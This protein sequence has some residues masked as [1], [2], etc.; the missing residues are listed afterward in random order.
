MVT[1]T[2]KLESAANGTAVVGGVE[3]MLCGYGSWVPRV[4]GKALV[5]R[6]QDSNIA[7]A[8][9]GSFSFQVDPND[10]IT[11]EGTYYTVTIK[12]D[13]GDISQINAY[14]F[15]SLPVSYDLTLV[16]PFSPNQPPPPLPPPPVFPPLNFNRL[17]ILP[18]VP[19]MVFDGTT[20]LSFKTT[21]HG[22]V[23]GATSQNMRPGNLYTFL[24][25]QDATGGHSFQ[26]PTN[27]HN[28]L[29]VSSLPNTTT[30]QT[31]VADENGELWRVGTAATTSLYF[32]GGLL[33][34]KDG[35]NKIF[36]LTNGGIALGATPFQA[37]VWL[38]FP[39]IPGVGYTLGPNP[40]QVTYTN[41]P[42]ALDSLYASGVLT[43]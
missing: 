30:V 22:D 37:S 31:F 14:R 17:V 16:D 10:A 18:A 29:P 20:Y 3:V 2:G 33:G 5:A 4:N 36:Q 32:S 42:K 12:D 26:W 7:I 41:A 25:V 1:V 11:P 34:T 9:D 28:A 21:L 15:L 24:V 6:I 35:V 27:T 23:T 19:N 43:P 39:L 40:G 38:N 13:N 8:S